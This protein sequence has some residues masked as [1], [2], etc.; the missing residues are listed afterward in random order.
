MPHFIA[1][2]PAKTAAKTPALESI[3][4]DSSGFTLHNIRSPHIS[5]IA[6]PCTYQSHTRL[7]FLQEIVRE[8]DVLVKCVKSL[9]PTPIGIA[10]DALSR[11][12]AHYEVL[13]D[14]LSIT[15][16]KQQVSSPF[17]LSEREILDLVIRESS[18]LDSSP[19]S[20]KPQESVPE[21]APK[22]T[23]ESSS[24]ESSSRFSHIILEIGFGSGRHILH[25]AR[26]NP[27]ALVLGLEIHTPS[28][29]QVLRQI[30]ILGLSNLY[31]SRLDARIFLQALPPRALRQIY[32]HFP[33]PWNSAK[34]RR[35]L[36]AALLKQVLR[37]LDSGGELE[38][39]TDDREYFSDVLG[40]A[41][42]LESASKS[43]ES[44]PESSALDSAPKALCVRHSINESQ[45]I[46]SK[47]EARW[48]RQSKDIYTIV[49][50]RGESRAE[51][52]TESSLESSL[53]SNLDSSA[54]SSDHA[55][56]AGARK[57]AFSF[58]KK[59]VKSLLA[60]VL[61]AEPL[62]L[63]R[64]G[65]W[66]C[67]QKFVLELDSTLESPQVIAKVESSQD[68]TTKLDSRAAAE[69][70]PTPSGFLRISDVYASSAAG[71]LALLVSFGD[72]AYPCSRL[73]LL[74]D[75]G[76]GCYLPEA[77]I[78]SAPNRKAHEQL[79]NILTT[80]EQS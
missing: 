36:S 67:A 41:H 60:K 20:T 79:I 80:L 28:I 62:E 12:S 24:P 25:V 4:L 11:L 10:K 63:A 72:F 17:L 55:E 21:S 69:N 42:A 49:M 13:Q 52:N 5:L 30:E 39:R 35:V 43:L 8:R 56:Q 2:L 68:S 65:E 15:S 61:A 34:H 40:L 78:E 51:S 54:D 26:A 9:R 75:S 19:K 18:P 50:Q 53:D 31:L 27:N 73:V 33:V 71:K 45:A 14:N 16:P 6:M 77:P 57:Y 76:Q 22:S 7:C 74:E 38:F 23:L 37:A 29:E 70:A 44:T 66:L 3:A 32:I 1:K 64:M 59:L 58:D 46:T 48:L 47:Y